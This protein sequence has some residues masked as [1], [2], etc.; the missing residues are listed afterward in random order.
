[1]KRRG[2]SFKLSIGRFILMERRNY[3]VLLI[4]KEGRKKVFIKKGTIKKALSIRDRF[5]KSGNK[6]D[7][8]V[9]ARIGRRWHFILLTK[10]KSIRLETKSI[11]NWSP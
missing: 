2:W 10:V 7:A 8:V 11:S 1:M 3:M 4:P 5:R 9:A 6:I